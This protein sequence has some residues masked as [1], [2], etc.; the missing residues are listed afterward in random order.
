[1]KTSSK[2]SSILVSI[3][4]I[5][6]AVLLLIDPLGFTSGIIIAI[7]AALF[8]FGAVN[9]VNYFKSTPE[10]AMH[11][12]G[13]TTGIVLIIAGVFCVLKNEWF[14]VTFPIISLLYGITT[15]LIGISKLQ[16]AVDMLRLKIKKWYLLAI[17]SAL[18][19]ILAVII[20]C[21][22]FTTTVVMW[23]FVAISLI[24]ESLVDIVATIFTK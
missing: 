4:E 22:P 8:V 3:C 16:W 15:L 9:V 6:I 7:G 17:S 5:I 12:R 23:T 2:V 1:M 18:T 19:I 20:L 10:E 13:L 14:I 24:V 21:N 11:E